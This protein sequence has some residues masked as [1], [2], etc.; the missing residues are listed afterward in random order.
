MKHRFRKQCL[1]EV[2]KE[3]GEEEQEEVEEWGLLSQKD[4]HPPLCLPS[5][6]L[7]VS[8]KSFSICNLCETFL[9]LLLLQPLG[10]PIWRSRRAE[11]HPLT[12]QWE[13]GWWWILENISL[14]G[15]CSSGGGICLCPFYHSNGKKKSST[16]G[17]L[18]ERDSLHTLGVE[19]E[20]VEV[21]DQI[22]DGD[23][24]RNISGTFLLLPFWVYIGY[25]DQ[26]LAIKSFITLISHYKIS[27]LSD[28]K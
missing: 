22:E 25:W 9:L 27:V 11:E 23:E 3:T 6:G 17:K 19:D 13:E 16:Q 28:T 24:R 18:S 2:D 10:H 5:G 20:E 14:N 4:H 8:A 26:V 12:P 21:V 1:L 7:P 15:C